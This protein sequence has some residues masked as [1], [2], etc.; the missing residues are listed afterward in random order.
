M[1]LTCIRWI[2]AWFWLCQVVIPVQGHAAPNALQDA[3]SATLAEHPSLVGRQF[4]MQAISRSITLSA[5][6]DKWQIGLPNRDRM[7][8]LVRV[9]VSCPSNPRFNTT[10]QIA[11]HVMVPVLVA[12]RNLAPGQAIQAEDWGMVVSD[13]GTL[14][15]D[16]IE[17]EQQALNKEVVRFIRAGTVLKLNDLRAM[18]VVRVGDLVKL[19]LVGQGFSVTS[20]GQAMSNGVV[21]GTVRVKTSEGKMLQGSVVS[22]G[23]VEVILD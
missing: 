3:L 21:G 6:C 9:Q 7:F 12:A 8:G 5:P 16:V 2:F 10:L 13:L 4:E 18:T 1:C 11:I 22:A 14:P 19:S 17:D 20:L 23:Q 15:S